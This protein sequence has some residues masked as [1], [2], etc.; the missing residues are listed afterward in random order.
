MTGGKFL[1]DDI[2]F[3]DLPKQ[4]KLENMSEDR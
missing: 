3:A 1:V 4:A 2:V